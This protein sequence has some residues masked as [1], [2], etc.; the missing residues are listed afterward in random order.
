MVACG[1]PS[2]S[3]V[4]PLINPEPFTVKVKLF[5]TTRVMVL[6]EMLEMDGTGFDTVR[7]AAAEVPPP[8]VGV[9]TV[10]DNCAPVARSEAGMAAVNC[11]LLTNVVVRLE[12]FTRTMEP[13]TK[14][15]PFTVSV[16]AALP[17]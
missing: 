7:V 16:I 8:G 1:L 15:L 6:G 10:I 5:P 3:T 12:P 17:A 9:K 11:V 4:D 14:L 2:T 13:L